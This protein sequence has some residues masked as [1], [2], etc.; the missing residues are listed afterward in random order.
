MGIL[1]KYQQ[2]G[3]VKASS[4]LIAAQADSV[5]ILKELYREAKTENKK[6]ELAKQIT[7]AELDLAKLKK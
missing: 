2:G 5:R 4:K 6:Q 7:K 1:Y 3:E